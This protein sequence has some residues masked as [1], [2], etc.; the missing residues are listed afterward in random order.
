MA[1]TFP[2]I[3]FHFRIGLSEAYK[4][5]SFQDGSLNFL[6]DT[7]RMYVEKD[8]LRFC[9]SDIIFDAGTEIDIISLQNPE[10]KIYLASDTYKLLYFDFSNLSWRYINDSSAYATTAG[11]ATFDSEQHNIAEYFYPKEDAINSHTSLTAQIK[12]LTDTISGINNYDT[13]VVHELS[14]L[15]STGTK[16]II[17]LLPQSAYYGADS[18]MVVSDDDSTPVIDDHFLELM[19]VEDVEFGGYYEIIGNTM[20]DLTN[21]YNKT[22]V[23]NAI[24]TA[25]SQI[26]D[27]IASIKS[28]I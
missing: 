26:E 17:Y 9:I 2:N 25:V 7:R 4:R 12:A 22:E 23:E 5:A 20:V 10:P 8:G 27:E 19:W 13:V 3:D 21:Y 16:G 18:A 28:S 1:T 24:S 6:K 14:E 15:P 11:S